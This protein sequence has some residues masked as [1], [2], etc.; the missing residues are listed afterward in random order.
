MEAKAR[1]RA[2]KIQ[3]QWVV[4]PRKQTNK[5][6]TS[7]ICNSAF[8]DLKLIKITV[9]RFVGTGSFLSCYSNG[10]QPRGLVVRASGY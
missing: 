8:H 10:D 5:Q 6:Y 4:T 1:Y 7:R 9:A 2:V 3:S